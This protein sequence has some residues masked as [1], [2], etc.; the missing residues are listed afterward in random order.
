M[1]RFDKI[2]VRFKRD[3]YDF[4]YGRIEN[5][6]FDKHERIEEH[7]YQYC[8]KALDTKR[9]S[10]FHE[11]ILEISFATRNSF[12]KQPMYKI[13]TDF[14]VSSEKE[15]IEA[16]RE[17]HSVEYEDYN[18]ITR[19]LLQFNL[20]DE[21]SLDDYTQEEIDT[22]LCQLQ[23]FEE[24]GVKAKIN[25]MPTPSLKDRNGEIQLNSLTLTDLTDGYMGEHLTRDEERIDH[26]FKNMGKLKKTMYSIAREKVDDSLDFYYNIKSTVKDYIENGE[27]EELKEC[28]SKMLENLDSHYD[29]FNKLQ[30]KSYEWVRNLTRCYDK[31]MYKEEEKKRNKKHAAV[32]KIIEERKNHE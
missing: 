4:A 28:L 9:E 6:F 18:D 30:S 24:E 12:E 14:K 8:G 10:K 26:I 16:W 3:E 29:E 13:F 17:N 32:K 27:N 15:M 21:N 19:L 25:E 2:N 11:I 5:F 7:N 1:S 31:Y 22:I 20:I 23:D